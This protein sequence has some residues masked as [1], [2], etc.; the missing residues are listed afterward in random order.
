M[1]VSLGHETQRRLEAMFSGTD[2]DEAV[3]VLAEWGVE[4]DRVR[5]AALK[6]SDG[7]LGKLKDAVAIGQ[8]DWRDL[9]HQAGFASDTK[10]HLRW[11]PGQAELSWFG[12]LLDRLKGGRG[13]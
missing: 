12:A 4:G 11:Q 1:V 2:R 5:I 10:K 3:R 7:Q 8:N 13:R 6:L 9:L